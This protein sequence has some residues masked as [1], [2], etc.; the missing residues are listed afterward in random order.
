[1]DT[2]HAAVLASRQ[3]FSQ[4]AL[5]AHLGP[6]GCSGL[7]SSNIALKFCGL[8]LPSAF[9]SNSTCKS[10]SLLALRCTI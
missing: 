4:G 8:F 7:D 6:E 1:M 2:A 3:V 5:V 9:H 10:I